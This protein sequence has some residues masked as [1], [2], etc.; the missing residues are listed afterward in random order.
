MSPAAIE[1]PEKASRTTKVPTGQLSGAFLD[2]APIDYELETEK[3]GRDGIKPAK[4][5]S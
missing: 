1:A 2:L 5:M 3:K 4:V